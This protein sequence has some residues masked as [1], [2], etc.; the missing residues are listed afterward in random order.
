MSAA[1]TALDALMENTFGTGTPTLPTPV[2][3]LKNPVKP[4]APPLT[5]RLT[6]DIPADLHTRLKVECARHG[7]TIN[8]MIRALLETRCPA[9]R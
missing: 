1:I 9:G 6:T 4:A 3:G 5:R 7:L 8:E 2:P